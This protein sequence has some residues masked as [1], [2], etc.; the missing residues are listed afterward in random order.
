M[1]AVR[2]ILNL[3]MVETNTS[4]KVSTLNDEPFEMAGAS[5]LKA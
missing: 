1:A 4:G 2:E 5:R 3:K